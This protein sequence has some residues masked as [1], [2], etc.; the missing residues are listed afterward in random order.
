MKHRETGAI[1]VRACPRTEI[2]VAYLMGRKAAIPSPLVSR[3]TELI[4]S[5]KWINFEDA[6]AKLK[7]LFRGN[8]WGMYL[9]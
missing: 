5:G 3:S 6:A 1:M 9:E 8:H 4:F 7:R 2:I